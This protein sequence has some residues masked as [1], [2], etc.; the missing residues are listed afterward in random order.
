MSDERMCQEN[1]ET[2]LLL[3]LYLDKL[4]KE[5]DELEMKMSKICCMM[6]SELKMQLDYN[7][8]I[9]ERIKNNLFDICSHKWETDHI[10]N[11]FSGLQK[12]EY[13]IY[14]ETMKS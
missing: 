4:R 14:C 3:K 1:Y 2:V 6:N 5:N 8:D 7:T 12:I 11:G 9:K 10:E 13:C